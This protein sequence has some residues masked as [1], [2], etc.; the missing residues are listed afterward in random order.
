MMIPG[1][2]SRVCLVAVSA[3]LGLAGCSGSHGSPAALPSS[4]RAAHLSF[5]EP[6]S[7]ADAASEFVQAMAIRQTEVTDRL[8]CRSRMSFGSW[9]LM[10]ASPARDTQLHF[11]VDRVRRT[12]PTS[13]RVTVAVQAGQDASGFHVH[14][15]VVKSDGHYR[16]CS[17]ESR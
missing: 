6:K 15:T 11:N 3:A 14:T 8:T 10:F 12:D 16:V 7:A 17:A 5:H 2:L 1:T 4:A 9:P 13:W